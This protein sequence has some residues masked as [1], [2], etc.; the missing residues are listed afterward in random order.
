MADNRFYLYC[1]SCGR[2]LYFASVMGIDVY[3]VSGPGRVCEWM[4]EHLAHGPDD[5]FTATP[6][7]VIGERHPRIDYSKREEWRDE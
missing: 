1:P 4:S 5:I 3:E 7:L 2:A 6:F